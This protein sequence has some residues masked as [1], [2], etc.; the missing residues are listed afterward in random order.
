MARFIR[1]SGLA[2]LMLI[3]CSA[4]AQAF[5]WRWFPYR[6]C[7]YA[8]V[9]VV[10]YYPAYVVPA[11]PTIPV[12][13]YATPKSAP[14]SQSGSQTDE[15]PTDAGAAASAL[16]MKLASLAVTVRGC[17]SA[18]RVNRKRPSDQPSS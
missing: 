11:C 5:G 10:Y 18:S 2:A 16:L 8:P 9:R 1:I 4:S 14:P 13:P 3:C 6:T 15:P 17:C 7:Y 12:M